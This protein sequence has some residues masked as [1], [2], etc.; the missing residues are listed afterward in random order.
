MKK[1]KIISVAICYFVSALW[2]GAQCM[3]RMDQI[4]TQIAL[5]NV[6]LIEIDQQISF[7]NSIVPIGT[8]IEY[9]GNNAP[10][11]NWL[12]CNGQAVSRTNYPEL[13]REIGVTYGMGDVL[14]TFNLPD[15][16]GR[17]SIGIGSDN[18]T[19]GLITNATALNITLGGVFGEE[20][21]QLTVNEL[22]SHTHSAIV[23]RLAQNGSDHSLAR[24]DGAAYNGVI[25]P[26]GGDQPH[27]NTQPS[28][29]MKFYI[30]A[31]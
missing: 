15:K 19:G 4:E 14:N 2:A 10:P 8:T 9:S 18:S 20:T 26:T 11:N 30:R 29:F 3:D 16:R 25:S 5:L 13:L 1:L 22:A 6:R 23:T 17:G 31:K 27:N 21:H 24:T 12:E 7:M 28:I